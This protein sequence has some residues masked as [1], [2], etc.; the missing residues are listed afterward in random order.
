M[1]YVTREDL[2]EAFGTDEIRQLADRDHSGEPDDGFVAS[3]IDA[4]CSYIDGYLAGRYALPL[5][6]PY[7]PVIVATAC[8]LSRCRLYEDGAPENVQKA[9]D[10]AKAW[11]RDV[12][13]GKTL[14]QLPAAITNLDTGSPTFDAPDRVFSA[15]TLGAF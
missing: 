4:A 12:S 11:L 1:A 9:C 13:S 3:A 6:E 14:L 7:P 5:L 15:E 10:A 8:D 2:E